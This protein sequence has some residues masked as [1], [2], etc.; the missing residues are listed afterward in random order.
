VRQQ[1]VTTGDARGDQVSILKGVDV[2]DEVVTA[3]QLKLHNGSPIMIDNSVK[4]LDNPA[5]VPVDH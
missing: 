2:N 5:P 1:F 3:G 4:L